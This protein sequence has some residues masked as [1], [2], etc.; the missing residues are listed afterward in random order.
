MWTVFLFLRVVCVNY[1]LLHQIWLLKSPN[2]TLFLIVKFF[3]VGEI[4]A[5]SKEITC[6]P[7]LKIVLPPQELSN[8]TYY[9][10][11]ISKLYWDYNFDSVSSIFC[12]LQVKLALLYHEVT[13]YVASQ[14]QP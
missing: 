12:F 5:R 2:W 1:M 11:S 4:A 6:P 14:L 10:C 7:T 3:I 9:C 8:L 13:M